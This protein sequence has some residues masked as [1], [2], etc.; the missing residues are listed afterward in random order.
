MKTFLNLTKFGIALFVIISGLIGYAIALPFGQGFDV[1]EPILLI[2]GLYCLSSGSFAINQAQEWRRDSLMDRTSKR[3][4][5]SGK[6]Y[7]WQA[8]V[9]GLFLTVV[10]V[11]FLYIL[12]SNA[13]L[14]GLLTLFLYNILYTLHWKNNWA[15]A[16]VPGAIPGAMPV[17]I[18]YAAQGGYILNSECVYLFLV[19][20]LWQMPHFWALAIRYKNDYA[21]A[22]IPVL[23]VSYGV[24]VTMNQIGLYTFA[25]VGVAL[26]APFFVNAHLLYLF[27]S[28]PLAIKVIYEFFKYFKKDGQ[29]QWLPFFL[30][31]NM[32][33]LAF[34]VAPVVDKWILYFVHSM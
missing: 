16:A 27:L 29:K 30:W 5:P 14:L 12:D 10:G 25:Y 18:G 22:G 31:V 4:L 8:W 26:A 17:V 2:V 11:F 19:M 3:P 20:F 1:I 24:D 6:M 33:M 23:P 15:F 32:S 34:L 28:L 9:L 21:S 7:V 13:A